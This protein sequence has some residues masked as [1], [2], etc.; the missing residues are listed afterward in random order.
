MS[1]F[2]TS[3]AI[4]GLNSNTSFLIFS[5][6]IQGIGLSMFIIPLSILQSEVSKEK[7]ALAN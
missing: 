3:I 4:A 1:I 5:R 2:I 7:H 6:F